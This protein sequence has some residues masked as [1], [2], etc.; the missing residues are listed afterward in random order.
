MA[1]KVKKGDTVLVI[2]GK[3]KGVKGKVIAGL[4]RDRPGP[5]R[6]RQPGQEAHQGRPRPSVAPRPA[7][8][9]P[10]RP[11]STSPTCMLVVE[12]DGKK[13]APAS[14]IR[15][16]D[17]G[18]ER[19]ASRSAPVRTSD[20]APTTDDRARRCRGSSRATATRSSPA[21]REQF[22]YANV[23]Q[24]PGLIKIVVNMGVGEAARDSKLIDGAVRDLATITGQ[25]P[26]GDRRPASRSRSSSCARACRSAPRSP[27][28]ATGCGSSSTG[29]CRSRCPRIRDFRGLSPQA[30]RRQRQLHVRS[31]RAVDVPRDRPGPDR[32]RRAA[33][34]SRSSPPRP[35]TTRAARC[36]A[37]SASRSRRTDPW[38]RRL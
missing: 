17:D 13:V 24:I 14:A 20:D 25:K 12:A 8:S 9:S 11:R 1:M 27:C 7:A 31:H 34:T 30:V 15:V 10:R 19:R 29:C 23:M 37:P 38:R 5:G 28:A 33:W 21:L 6:G 36:C 32:P 35:T 3:D 22:G 4:P 26:T 16:D 18:N 2:A